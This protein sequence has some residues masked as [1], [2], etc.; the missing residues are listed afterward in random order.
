[1]INKRIEALQEILKQKKLA[2]I[3]IPTQDFHMSEYVGE[4]FKARR[5]FSGFT[6]SAGVMVITQNQANL[7]TDGRYFIQA[8]KELAGSCVVL[9]K[10]GEEGV[11]TVKEY[12][13]KTL[14]S[15]DVL[16]FDG[17][18]ISTK[19]CREYEEELGQQGVT[20]YTKEDLVGLV[21][22]DRPAL[23]CEPAFILR[24]KY[25]GETVV[26]KLAKVRKV[27]AE[28]G[29]DVH[30]LGSLDDIAWLFNI[31]GNDVANTPVVLSY[32]A[33]TMDNAI[34]FANSNV[35]SSEMKGE[36][37]KSGVTL[38][39][40][41][42]IYSYAQSIAKEK[43]VMLDIAR[44]NCAI[45]NAIKAEI[46]E[47]ENPEILLKAV[48]N[49]IEVENTKLGHIYDGV[50]VTKFMYWLKTNVGKI[51]I[52]ELSAQNYLAKLRSEQPGFIDLSFTTIA[53]YKEHAAMMHYSANEETDVE[54]KAEGMLLVD[55]GGQY[56][57]GTTDI[58]RTFVLGP[59]TPEQKL[60]FTTIVQ[61]VMAVS[62]LKFL[63]GCRGI[64]FDIMAREPL[65]EMGLDY[66]CGTGHGVGYLLNVHE[67]PNGFRW[68]AAPD[69][70]EGA[71][72]Q[73]GM[74]T[75]IE[76]GVYIEG[77]HGIRTENELLCCKGEKNEY[78]QFLYFEPITYAPI[79]LDGIEP[80]RM[81]QKER[82][83]L[84]DYHKAV[85]EKISPYLNQE[86]KEWLKKYTSAI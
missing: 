72:F 66:K 49:P 40:Y 44:T 73:E 6:G 51:K 76:P 26:D 41:D 69:R 86:E 24:E 67:G 56:Y 17:R 15:G 10:M 81:S 77:S 60:H 42:E 78:G 39:E 33:I 37:E 20:L 54:L 5:Y 3:I 21:W 85:Y 79:D 38:K 45:A 25:A 11:P 61:S 27:M 13:K 58:T 22:H 68:K 52:T 16:C 64:N 9:Q 2:A 4:Y 59:I 7:W 19:E 65:W 34:I 23:S 50:A 36:L 75:T 30:I 74:I 8:P 57:N 80:E 1:M 84:N 47:V 12:L 43:K 35:F 53:G 71:V 55:S 29:A 83:W 48:K 82:N 70:N 46:I 32:G 62:N 28:K 31:R 18:V 63:Q 14:K